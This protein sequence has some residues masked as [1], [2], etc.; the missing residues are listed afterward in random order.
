MTSDTEKKS[1]C[2]KPQRP[3]IP[4]KKLKQTQKARIS[5]WMFEAVCKYYKEHQQMPPGRIAGAYVPGALSQT[6]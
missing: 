6:A 2:K 4:Y 3:Q 1:T 5:K